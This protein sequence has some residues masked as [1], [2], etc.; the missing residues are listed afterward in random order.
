MPSRRCTLTAA[1]SLL[2]F[3]PSA[4]AHIRMTQPRP[5]NGDTDGNKN[6]LGA[7]NP[8]P[9]QG[10][11]PSHPY[12]VTERYTPGQPAAIHLAGSATHG[13][14]SCQISLSYDQGESFRVVESIIGG[15]PL[16]KTLDFTIPSIAP[17]GQALLAWTWFNKIGESSTTRARTRD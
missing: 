17:P 14:G 5:L 16:N 11:I 3:I 4:Q 15:C 1:W 2:I 6:P 8:Y 7:G 9:C 13:G 12:S 10:Y